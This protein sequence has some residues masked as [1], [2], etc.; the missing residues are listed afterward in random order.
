MMKNIA[1]ISGTVERTGIKFFYKG[2]EFERVFVHSK[3]LS[4]VV[5]KVSVMIP[6][7]IDTAGEK[8]EFVG[9][10]RMRNFTNENRKSCDVFMF[11]TEV[12]EYGGSDV[13]RIC[14]DGVIVRNNGVRKTP[15]GKTIIDF[16][17]ANNRIKRPYYIPCIAWNRKALIVNDMEVGTT[18]TAYGKFQSRE[19]VKKYE[20][21]TEATKTAYE[22]SCTHVVAY[23]SEE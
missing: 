20:D 13:N 14:I 17:I 4:G 18:V 5:D 10:L 7:I 9:E 15:L 8:A 22:L 12:K 11:A 16:I 2:E 6:K 21:G 23:E 1:K 19:Y 3:R